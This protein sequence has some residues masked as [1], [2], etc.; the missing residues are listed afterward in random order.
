MSAG[1]YSIG[2]DCWP[3]LA[4][5]GEE[6]SEA[7]QVVGKIIAAGGESVHWD[8]SDLRHRLQE[9]IADVLAA[10]EFLTAVNGLD[11]QA[12]ADRYASKITTFHRWHVEHSDGSNG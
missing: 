7:G 8:G 5:L 10:A 4:K 1:P 9:E 11:R 12:I 3:G 2:S 6:C